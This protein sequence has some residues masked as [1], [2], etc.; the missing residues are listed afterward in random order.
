MTQRKR[1]SNN[2]GYYDDGSKKLRSKSKE[3][4]IY[5][6]FFSFLLVSKHVTCIE[7]FSNE[8]FLEIFD[9]LDGCDV[10]K[11]FSNL[12]KR[13]E[14]IISRSAFRPKISLSSYEQSKDEDCWR[15]IIFPNKPKIVSLC[16]LNSLVIDSF[17]QSIVFDSLF[18]HL[19]SIVL[20]DIKSNGLIPLLLALTSIPQLYLLIITV[21]DRN[22]ND[23]SNVYRLIFNLSVLKYN[24]LCFGVSIPN[25]SVKNI[26][27]RVSSIKHLNLD[28]MCS[29]NDLA[30]IFSYTSHL[31][32][33][34]CA[35]LIRSYQSIEK[36]TISLPYLTHISIGSCRLHFHELEILIKKI[37]SSL[38]TLRIS[39]SNN[40]KYLD[41]DRWEQLI[42]QHIPYLRNF[43]FEYQEIINDNFEVTPDHALIPKF[44]SSFWHRRQW[45]FKLE[46]NINH[47][48]LTEVTYSIHPYRYIKEL[49]FYLNKICFY[50]FSRKKWYESYKLK[51]NE[52]H[53]NSNTDLQLSNGT[54]LTIFEHS[55][56]D[57]NEPLIDNMHSFFDIVQITELDVAFESIFVGMLLDLLRHLP[58]L[59]SLRVWSLS[60]IKPRCLHA[61]EEEI[62]RMISTYNKIRK[63]NIRRM[64]KITQ[65]Q[66]LIDLCPL[67]EYFEIGISSNFDFK[68]LVKIILI[69]NRKRISHLRVLCFCIQAANDNVIEELQD[70]LKLKKLKQKFTIERID[71]R[72]Y[73]QR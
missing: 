32:R 33:I 60:L 58:N 4:L 37:S 49:C 14:N 6:F 17:S 30:N 44:N 25:I 67:M 64:T 59:N 61:A 20:F 12:N 42:L 53:Y 28:H 45:I 56:T 39:T 35:K 21:G 10:Y 2:D 36:I 13:F 48:F 47:F 52:K 5:F 57:Y 54:E 41:A 31:S 8:L 68:S 73:I 71:N 26:S 11:V 7:D 24:K 22:M 66:F 62:F 72:I 15:N 1:Q 40:E 55:F 69:K 27:T 29:L 3:C 34:V 18:Q 51:E 50:L 16:L 63:V 65:V 9:Y 43:H 46:I 23:F 70:M 19:E 38:Q